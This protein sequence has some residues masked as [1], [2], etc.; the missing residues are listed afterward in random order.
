MRAAV[1]AVAVL[2]SLAN[3]AAG[4]GYMTVPASRTRLAYE[5]GEDPLPEAVIAEP[6]PAVASGRNY[7]GDRPAAEPGLMY[8]QRGNGEFI[9]PCG[10]SYTGQNYNTPSPAGT[11]GKPVTTYT[12]GQ[13]VETEICFD[14]NGNH[15]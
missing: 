6:I 4:H 3:L 15:G 8:P 12:P 10:T 1:S 9:G 2:L 7:P 13:T 5:K 14:A 11:W